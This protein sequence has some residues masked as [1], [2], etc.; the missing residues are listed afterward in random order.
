MDNIREQSLILFDGSQNL[1]KRHWAAYQI[2]IESRTL[3]ESL[4]DTNFFRSEMQ[5]PDPERVQQLLKSILDGSSNEIKNDLIE[6]EAASA[7]IQ[8]IFFRE[9]EKRNYFFIGQSPV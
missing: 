1:I 6:L 4:P 5:N 8:D 7:I 2:C 9:L 3:H